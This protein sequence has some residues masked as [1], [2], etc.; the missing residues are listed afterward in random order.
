MKNDK[1]NAS[2]FN[3]RFVREVHVLIY[4]YVICIYKNREAK[5]NAHSSLLYLSN[6]SIYSSEQNTCTGFL[7][8]KF[9]PLLKPE[10]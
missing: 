4:G 9:A 2:D 7:G 6:L 8:R 5:S 1:K 10:R 3:I